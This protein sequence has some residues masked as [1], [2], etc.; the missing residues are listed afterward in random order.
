MNDPF[1]PIHA[2]GDALKVAPGAPTFQ[3]LAGLTTNQFGNKW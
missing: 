1:S 3:S 2:K